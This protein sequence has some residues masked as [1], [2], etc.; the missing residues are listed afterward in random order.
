MEKIIKEPTE[1][2][3]LA[4]FAIVTEFYDY[5]EKEK[6]SFKDL[7]LYLDNLESKNRNVITSSLE[8]LYNILIEKML[9]FN[10]TEIYGI[11]SK[12]VKTISNLYSLKL[13]IKLQNKYVFL[14]TL[15]ELT[16]IPEEDYLIY[17]KVF[18]R[19]LSSKSTETQNLM[20]QRL[21][22]IIA[23]EGIEHNNLD[24][25]IQTGIM[26]RL[27]YFMSNPSYDLLNKVLFSVLSL[28]LYNTDENSYNYIIGIGIFKYLKDL[29][30]LEKYLQYT[31][32]IICILANRNEIDLL[33]SMGFFPIFKKLI[34]LSGEE[35]C[36]VMPS[37]FQIMMSIVHYPTQKQL[38]YLLSLGYLEW[39]VES[40]MLYERY[41]HSDKNL[42]SIYFCLKNS[43]DPSPIYDYL[44][45][46]NFTSIQID[47]LTKKESQNLFYDIQKMIQDY[48]YKN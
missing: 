20:V 34:Y 19:L 10:K 12:Y 16:D 15:L 24:L 41:N 45:E 1:V 40:F 11:P 23:F 8:V 26:K 17:L 27:I 14:F 6:I 44:I 13:G 36:M 28:L 47:F 29:L 37:L 5:F 48:Q 38:K 33:I 18:S 3:F 42:S 22:E 7:D 4:T 35:L 21:Y 46:I 43:E 32:G 2:S 39:F 9:G 31:V 30:V 25:L